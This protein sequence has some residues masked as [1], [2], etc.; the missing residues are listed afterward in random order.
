MFFWKDYILGD[1]E[2]F[3][4]REVELMV[5]EGVV[6]RG[7]RFFVVFNEIMGGGEDG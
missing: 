7:R 6:E 4:F 2:V 3:V 5:V 1:G